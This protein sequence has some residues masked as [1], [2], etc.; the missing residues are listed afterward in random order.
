MAARNSTEPASS[1]DRSSPM[2]C[3]AIHAGDIV[4]FN[5]P[6]QAIK[7][8]DRRAPGFRQQFGEMAATVQLDPLPLPEL[9][10]R[11]V[12]AVK[13]LIDMD[14]WERQVA[15]QQVEF[16]CITTIAQQFRGLLQQFV[17]GEK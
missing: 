6:P 5:L 11:M 1:S 8:T 14:T 16:E 17:G 9:R 12:V 15:I 13:R 10:E 4:R 2:L 3:I 7:S